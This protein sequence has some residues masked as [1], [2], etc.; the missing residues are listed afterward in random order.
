[1]IAD[2]ASSFA[3]AIIRL[4]QDPA[5]RRNYEQAAAALAERYDWSQIARRFAE[6]LQNTVTSFR[7][8]SG[9]KGGSALDRGSPSNPR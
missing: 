2:D 5:L 3:A 1:M 7:S 8:T 9:G 6:V 4:L